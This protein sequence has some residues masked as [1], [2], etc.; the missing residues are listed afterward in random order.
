MSWKGLRLLCTC[1]PFAVSPAYRTLV[2]RCE[3]H[4]EL[5]AHFGGVLIGVEADE[6]VQRFRGE[7]DHG[8]DAGSAKGGFA[9]ARFVAEDDAQTRLRAVID[10]FDVACATQSGE[11]GGGFAGGGGVAQ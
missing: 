6:E 9:G 5:A 10:A 4:G 2:L 8:F 11:P 3:G 1:S 7:F